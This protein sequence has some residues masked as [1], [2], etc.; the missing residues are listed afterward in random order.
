MNTRILNILATTAIAMSAL[1]CSCGSSKE[2][3]KKSNTQKSS[4][5]TNT[6]KSNTA[7]DSKLQNREKEENQGFR[8]LSMD[9]ATLTLL[10]ASGSRTSLNGSIRICRDSIIICSVTPFAGVNMEF[11]RIGV[12]KSGVTIMDRINKKYFFMTYDELQ[13]KFGMEMN[14]NAF[15]SIFTNR[16]FVYN[17][18]YIPL[19]SDFE[20]SE[21]GEQYLFARA[22]SKVNQ[23]FYF[24]RSKVLEGGMISAGSQYSMRWNYADFAEY[25]NVQ[26][27]K[28]LNLKIAGPDF[29][30]QM[31][32]QYKDVELDRDR[33]FKFEVPSSYERVSLED[34]L[35]AL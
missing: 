15:E 1:F 16:V 24:N 22:D 13:E 10:N 35:K 21:L 11:A 18:P 6:Q 27:P 31:Q 17:F 34:L 8:T 7:A 25:N 32:I 5:K 19:T 2:T 20:I 14:Y 33:S 3:T 9:K 12:N 26:F 4:A 29:R 23:E 30:R 28:R